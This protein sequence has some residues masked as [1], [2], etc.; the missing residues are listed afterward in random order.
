MGDDP[1]ASRVL[2][3]IGWDG[4]LSESER[5]TATRVRAFVDEAIRP[6]IAE[7]YAAGVLRPPSCPSWASSASLACT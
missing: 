7:W 1:D 4:L 2:R 5:A 6:N 3:L